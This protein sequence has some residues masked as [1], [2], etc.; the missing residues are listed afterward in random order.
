MRD[1]SKIVVSY[2]DGMVVA[3]FFFV[4]GQDNYKNVLASAECF[5]CINYEQMLKDPA[6]KGCSLKTY[7][8]ADGKRWIGIRYKERNQSPASRYFTFFEPVLW[9]RGLSKSK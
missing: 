2:K 8:I 5:A 9:D 3:C 1:C 6:S 7:E 4:K